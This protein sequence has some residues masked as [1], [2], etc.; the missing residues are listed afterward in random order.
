MCKVLYGVRIDDE[1]VQVSMEMFRLGLHLYE[2]CVLLSDKN[3]D[4]IMIVGEIFTD[5]KEKNGVK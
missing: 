1:L 2:T 3:S 5:G 4:D